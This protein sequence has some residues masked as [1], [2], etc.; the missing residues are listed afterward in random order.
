MLAYLD[1]SEG[2]GLSILRQDERLGRVIIQNIG[3]LDDLDM[4]IR[5][6]ADNSSEHD[7]VDRADARRDSVECHCQIALGESQS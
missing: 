1:T 2:D 4:S 6:I 5:R 7:V 3:V